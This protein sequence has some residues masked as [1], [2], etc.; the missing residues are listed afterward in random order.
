MLQQREKIEEY[1]AS[2]ADPLTK[3][4]SD[5]VPLFT[6][7]YRIDILFDVDFDPAIVWDSHVP[8]DDSQ[9]QEFEQA[10]GKHA[11]VK[12]RYQLHAYDKRQRDEA[13]RPARTPSAR[14]RNTPLSVR[15]CASSKPRSHSRATAE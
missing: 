10:L 12:L 3:M 4:Y 15:R 14:V 1:L 2:L 13:V 8:V 11:R 9:V 7:I 6:K 5:Q